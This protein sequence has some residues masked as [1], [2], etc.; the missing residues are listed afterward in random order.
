[1][2][3]PAL[4]TNISGRYTVHDTK[5]NGHCIV[6]NA[7][8]DGHYIVHGA[9]NYPCDMVHDPKSDGRCIVFFT[10]ISG[11]DMAFT[12]TFSEFTPDTTLILAIVTM[13]TP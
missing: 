11:D 3:A 9:N 7:K 10:N 12:L 1:M 2:N 6:H 13:Q 4:V 8:S 5:S